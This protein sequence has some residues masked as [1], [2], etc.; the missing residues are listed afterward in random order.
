M[1]A[2]HGPSIPEMESIHWNCSWNCENSEHYALVSATAFEGAGM[3]S[4]D[5]KPASGLTRPRDTA[6][7]PALLSRVFHQ[8]ALVYFLAVTEYRSV[9]E[10]SRRLGIASS[11]V[12]RQIAL[13]EDALGM[14]LF[15]RASQR[16]SLN[17]GRRNPL[18]PRQTPDRA[19]GSGGFRTRNAARP[20]NWHGPHRGGRECWTEFPADAD[21][22]FFKVLPT[23]SPRHLDPAG[24]WGDRGGRRRKCRYRLRVRS[25]KVAFGR[26]RPAARRAHWRV[27][28]PPI[29][30]WRRASAWLSATALPIRWRSRVRKYRYARLSN[31]SCSASPI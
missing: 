11:A 10:A 17:P 23:P 3:K 16:M 21:R 22:G 12:T 7:S 30:R 20:Q 24:Q 8:P 13:L 31:R 4:P 1:I 25:G 2:R 19:D 9:R 15:H 26:Y 6:L 28:A 14:A 29:T 5:S 27:D 18:P